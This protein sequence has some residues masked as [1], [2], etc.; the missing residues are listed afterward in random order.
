MVSTIEEYN[1]NNPMKPNQYESTKNTS[2]RKPLHQFSDKLN[3]KHKTDVS[4]L[5]AAKSNHK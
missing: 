5:G 4:R 2:A 1:N 3:T